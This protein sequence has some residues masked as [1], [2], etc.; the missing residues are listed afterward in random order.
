[1]KRIVVT[2]KKKLASAMMPYWIIAG[3]SKASFKEAHGFQSDLC[4]M[5][6]SGFAVSRISVEELDS[7]GTRIGN[8]QTIELEVPD[9][10]STL[11]VSTMDGCLSNEAAVDG[12]EI[13]VSTAGGFRKLPCPVIEVK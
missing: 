9:D 10:V 12:R 6:E 4:E 7:I 2:R 13:I 3:P 5:A 1:M 11:F 8:G